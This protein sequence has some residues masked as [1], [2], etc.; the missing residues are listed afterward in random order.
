MVGRDSVGNG[1]DECV[2]VILLLALNYSSDV[3]RRHTNRSD[4]GADGR[5]GGRVKSGSKPIVTD[6]LL[7]L[8]E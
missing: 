6:S 3:I 5:E 4:Y 8:N 7:A 1:M 2:A